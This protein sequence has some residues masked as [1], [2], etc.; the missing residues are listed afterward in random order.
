MAAHG[1]G[2]VALLRAGSAAGLRADLARGPGRPRLARAPDVRRLLWLRCPPRRRP[3]RGAGAG[4]SRHRL[5]PARA[6]RL[7]RPPGLPIPSLAP[8]AEPRGPPSALRAP[9][10]DR[11]APPGTP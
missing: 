6:P 4:L 8:R 5:V 7:A 9:P 3:G 10:R 11:R 2:A 1:N